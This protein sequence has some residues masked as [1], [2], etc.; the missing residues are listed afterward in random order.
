MSWSFNAQGSPDDV[1]AA[2]ESSSNN[3]LTEPSLAEW[4]EAKPA[5][6]TLVKAN[7]GRQILMSANGHG[8]FSNGE[9]TYGA[10]SVQLSEFTQAAAT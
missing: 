1:A 8:A 6:L 4:S 10:C 3:Q 9:K 2:I 7:K 5:L